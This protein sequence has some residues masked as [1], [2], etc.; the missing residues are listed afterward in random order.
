MEN[1]II[2]LEEPVDY[3]AVEEVTREAFWNHHSSGCDEH[4]LV[5]IMRTS[6]AFIK[7]LAYVAVYECR[8]IGN[9]MYTKAV[10][11][12]DDNEKHCVLSF[13]PVSV[14]PEFQGQGSCKLFKDIDVK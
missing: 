13:G 5:N 7:E 12:G 14:L 4:Y 8:S 6:N 11:L 3:R 10:V 9:I 1:L 2:R